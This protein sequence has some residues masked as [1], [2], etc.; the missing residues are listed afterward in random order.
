[1]TMQG[2]LA[3]FVGFARGVFFRVLYLVAPL[4]H[5]FMALEF[6]VLKYALCVTYAAFFYP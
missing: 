1:M 6:C 3:T 5:V 4:R 2:F